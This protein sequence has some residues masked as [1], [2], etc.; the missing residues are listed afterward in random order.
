MN[1]TIDSLDID[2]GIGKFIVNSQITN[3]A[4][5]QSGVGK[6]EL[7]LLGKKDD[8]KIKSKTGLGS[9]TIDG[10]KIENKQVTGNGDVYINIEAGVGQTTVNFVENNI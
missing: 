7:N 5:I 10:Q 3:K 2:G 8:Y 4:D 9:F 1:S 6:L